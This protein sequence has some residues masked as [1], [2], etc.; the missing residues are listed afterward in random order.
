MKKP[1]RSH[2]RKLLWGL[3]ILLIVLV[4][5][6]GLHGCSWGHWKSWHDPERMDKRIND[7]AEHVAEELELRAD[8]QAAYARLVE[9]FK[10]H[11]RGRAGARRN[12]AQALKEAFSAE[13]LDAD[14][15]ATALRQLVRQRPQDE[16]LER[17]IDQGLEF[18]RTLSPE[19]QETF[20]AKVHRHLKW[21][22]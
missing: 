20:R 11:A 16:E 10:A 15:V 12:S 1:I 13:S 8:Q 14:R 19:Q 6:V 17:L 2:A 7:A 5:V 3:P 9:Q 21:H 18:Y 22:F 4:A